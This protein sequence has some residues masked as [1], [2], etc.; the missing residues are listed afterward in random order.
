MF[1]DKNN[2]VFMEAL[3]QILLHILN[4]FYHFNLQKC[5]GIRRI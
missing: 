1:T 5:V 2:L 4:M 3:R